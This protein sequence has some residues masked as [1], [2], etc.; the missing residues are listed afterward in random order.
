M[1]V[2][3]FGVGTKSESPAITAQKRINCYVE[4]RQEQD[5]TVFSLVDRKSVV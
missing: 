1:R 5:R 2:N 3:L 4:T